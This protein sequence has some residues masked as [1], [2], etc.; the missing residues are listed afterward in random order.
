[1]ANDKKDEFWSEPLL[2]VKKPAPPTPTRTPQ[3]PLREVKPP[4]KVRTKRHP[5]KK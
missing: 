4:G 2:P 3:R 5:V 1:M